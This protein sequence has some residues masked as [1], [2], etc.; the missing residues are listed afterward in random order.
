LDIRNA[1]GHIGD[2][3]NLEVH[4]IPRNEYNSHFKRTRN[5]IYVLTEKSKYESLM[6]LNDK[7]IGHIDPHGGVTEYDNPFDYMEASDK[8]QKKK[9]KEEKKAPTPVSVPQAQTQDVD[10]FLKWANEW[11][12]ISLASGLVDLKVDIIVEEHLG[13]L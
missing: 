11:D 10:E 9:K 3:H 4:A 7:V 6:V 12:P 2:Y 1:R 8:P 13:N 5:I